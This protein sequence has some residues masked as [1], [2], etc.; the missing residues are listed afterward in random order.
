MKKTGDRTISEVDQC[1]EKVGKKRLRKLK[2]YS[3]G[4]S[5]FIQIS[6]NYST[7]LTHEAENGEK[8][9]ERIMLE[10]EQ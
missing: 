4:C 6:G 7:I 1:K 3:L 8:V 5:K 10:V 2:E 9:G